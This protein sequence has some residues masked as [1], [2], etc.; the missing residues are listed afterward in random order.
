[1]LAGPGSG[2]LGLALLW[3]HQ[4]ASDGGQMEFRFGL[5]SVLRRAPPLATK[6]L[7]RSALALAK[8]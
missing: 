1:M 7:Y 2:A 3:M 8:T 6:D 5:A 4:K